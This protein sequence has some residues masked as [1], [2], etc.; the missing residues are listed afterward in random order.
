MTN[1]LSLKQW[2]EL[3]NTEWDTLLLGNGSSVVISP[4]FQYRTLASKAD[5]DASTA[6]LLSAQDSPYNFESALHALHTTSQVL[7]ILGE[8]ASPSVQSAHEALK[9]GLSTAIHRV[10]PLYDAV[11][12]IEILKRNRELKRYR[13]VFTT[14]YDLLVYWALADR[15]FTGFD[16]GFRSGLFVGS[17]SA[18]PYITA[19][20]FLHGAF[21]LRRG[22]DGSDQKCAGGLLNG[23]LLEQVGRDLRWHQEIQVV[24]EGKAQTKRA[25]IEGSTY[26]R[27]AFQQLRE[28]PKN[29]VVLGSSLSE[30]DSHLWKQLAAAV[31][32]KRGRAAIGVYGA[33]SDDAISEVKG[34]AIKYFEQDR[35][36]FFDSRSHIFGRYRARDEQWYAKHWERCG[37][38]RDLAFRRGWRSLLS[39]PPGNEG[40]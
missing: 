34:Q 40:T 32:E 9:L 8:T 27:A 14:N 3:R 22:A 4:H 7:S 35:L 33:A 5:L 24:T 21:H 23:S 25:R 2:H 29:V 15:R 19:V 39:A 37:V 30:Q 17:P 26:L 28:R 1:P 10:H 6:Q 18:S 31:T 11:D 16:D 13:Q 20:W 36:E 12:Q 38:A